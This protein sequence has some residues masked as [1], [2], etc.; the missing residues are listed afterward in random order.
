MPLPFFLSLFTEVPSR[1][2]LGS[3]PQASG[4]GIMLLCR[5]KD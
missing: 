3:S 1:G 4:S 2:V 5:P